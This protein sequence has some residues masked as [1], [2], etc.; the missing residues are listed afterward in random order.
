MMTV[1]GQKPLYY[2]ARF[3]TRTVGPTR[4]PTFPYTCVQVGFDFLIYVAVMPAESLDAAVD[5][6]NTYWPDAQ[7][8]RVVRNEKQMYE[9][10]V[11]DVTR[12]G[13]TDSAPVR[14]REDRWSLRAWLRHLR[15]G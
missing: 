7:V 5:T 8:F 4:L 13:Y 11:T 12:M 3:S 15:G 1:S 14:V 6:V 9:A 10:V 2:H